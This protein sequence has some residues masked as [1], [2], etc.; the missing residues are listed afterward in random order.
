MNEGRSRILPV[1]SGL[2]VAVLVL[3]NILAVKMVRLGPFLFDGGTLLFPLSYVF[4]DILTEVYGYRASRKVIWTGLG[5]LVL[6]SLSIWLIGVLPAD[7]SWGMQGAYDSILSPMPRIALAS[8]LGYFAGEWSNSALLSRMKVLTKG[9]W[10][11]TR[12]IGSTLVGQASDTLI[13]VLVAFGGVY[14]ASDIVAMVLS[15]YLFKCAIEI[16]FTPVTYRAVGFVKRSEGTD[17]YDEGVR[18]NPLP[19]K[20]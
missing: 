15:N 10:L 2:F 9:R 17:V 20:D 7:G 19:V 14:S 1:L 12:T 11:W 5:S 6:M 4:G 16:V 18:Y 8:V 13:F 3:S